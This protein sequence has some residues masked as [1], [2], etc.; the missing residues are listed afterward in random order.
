MAE[1]IEAIELRDGSIKAILH[2][3]IPL[4][5]LKQ[6]MS[7]LK[8]WLKLTGQ[9]TKKWYKYATVFVHQYS[10]FTFMYL[11]KT[12]NAKET[13]QGKKAFEAVSQQ[14]GIVVRH[15]HADNG[16]F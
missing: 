13:I 4:K 15:Y 7:Q 6:L 10:G 12:S 1:S 16:I 3:L 11:Q 8:Q 9:L 14:H 5:L 2:C